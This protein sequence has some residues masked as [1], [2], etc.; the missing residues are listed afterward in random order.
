MKNK[1]IEIDHDKLLVHL[2]VPLT[3]SLNEV[4]LWHRRC[5]DWKLVKHRA[6]QQTA[7]EA[8]LNQRFGPSWKEKTPLAQRVRLHVVRCTDT[9]RYLDQTNLVGG[10][11]ATE[12]A[13]VQA[14]VMPDDTPAH[15]EW[16]E[17]RQ[18]RK[19]EWGEY[20]GP[21]THIYVE[22]IE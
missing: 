14:G 5:D 17:L 19:G 13:M 7:V 10:L 15:A 6:A 3:P 16:G 20:R 9:N 21:A 2:K 22:R 18:L 8:C 1:L 4:N 11:K 12:D